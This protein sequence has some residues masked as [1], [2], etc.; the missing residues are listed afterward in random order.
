[1]KAPDFPIFFRELHGHEPFPWQA[2]LADEVCRTNLWPDLLDLPT[3]SGKTACIDVALFHWLVCAHRGAPHDA[4]RR[5]AFVV[6]RRIIVDEAEARARHIADQIARAASPLLAAQKALLEAKTSDAQVHVVKLRGGVERE[7]NIARDPTLL[8]VILSTVDQIGSRLLFRGYGVSDRMTP[9][10][11]GIFGVDTLLLLD[12]AHIAEPFQKTLEAIVHTQRKQSARQL[13]PSPL[14]WARLSATAKENAEARVFR[15]TAEDGAH[16][17]LARRLKAKKPM[18]LAAVEKRDQL[19]RAMKELVA[20][21]LAKEPLTMDEAPRIAVV[22]NRVSTARAVYDLLQAE[23]GDQANSEL[24]IGR[25]RPIDRDDR[26][27]ALSRVLRSSQSPR[28]G[29]RPIVVVA[30]QT[31]EVGADFDFHALFTEAASYAAIKQRV[32]RLNRLGVRQT[33]RGAVVLIREDAKG[34]PIYG[35]TTAATWALL[36]RHAEGGIVDLGIEYAPDDEHGTAQDPK[37][38]PVLSPSLLGLL[39]QT[40]PRP[41]AEPSVAEFL[42]GFAAEIPD[43]SVVWRDG[44]TDSSG[45]IDVDLARQVLSALPPLSH[46]AMSLPFFT[47]R[48]WLA[49]ARSR[50]PKLPRIDDLGDIEGD[51]ERDMPRRDHSTHRVLMVTGD[52]VDYVPLERVWPGAKVVLPATIGGADRFGFAP[53][54]KERVYDLTFRAREASDGVRRGRTPTVVWTPALARS[55]VLDTAPD[56]EEAEARTKAVQ[57]VLADLDSGRDDVVDAIDK[58]FRTWGGSL[59]TDAATTL[60]AVLGGRRRPPRTEW[61]EANGKRVGLVLRAPRPSPEDVA[62]YDGGLLQTVLVPLVDHSRGVAEFAERFARAVGLEEA[63]IQAIRK[64]GYVHDLGKADPR[65]QTRLGAEPHEL[66]AKSA[67]YDRRTQLGERHE[68]YSVALLD[69][70]PELLSGHPGLE[71]LIR[72]LVGSHHGFGRA[73]QPVVAD[74]RGTS[75]QLELDGLQ[76]SYSG[77]PGLGAL[78]SGWCDL[79]AELHEQYGPWGLAYLESILRLADHRRSEHEVTSSRDE[80]TG[81]EA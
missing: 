80:D 38:T 34:D 10:H 21:E 32:G 36:E 8:T 51:L 24:V 13:G 54:S 7:E 67:H 66:L 64:A 29:D 53:A 47:F 62:E 77:R 57:D 56:G 39:V 41:A 23:L 26:M 79:F 44:L 58:W 55:W 19:P 37:V 9:I 74:D 59:R 27:A 69:Q 2:R 25:V 11:A 75:F 76:L 71:R 65:F 70:H 18:Q 31:I 48:Q 68:A 20:N 78:G 40:H 6:D 4:C 43:V 16:P 81:G 30:T 22:V 61:L 63:L 45:E 33:A 3:G 17:V 52:D 28:P 72:Y 1:M 5:V 49:T 42:H 14:R 12:E 50:D 73:F 46:E 35:D 60:A 15:L